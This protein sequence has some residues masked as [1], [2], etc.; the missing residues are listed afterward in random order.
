MSV[1]PVTVLVILY[2]V[3]DYYTEIDTLQSSVAVLRPLSKIY[4]SWRESVSDLMML[5]PSWLEVLCD[6]R[7]SFVVILLLPASYAIA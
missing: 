5:L 4:P 6:L 3:L 2:L 1:F 7:L